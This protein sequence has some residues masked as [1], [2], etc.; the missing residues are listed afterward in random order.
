MDCIKLTNS[1]IVSKSFC[2]RTVQCSLYHCWCTSG[3]VV[4][5]LWWS[6]GH[7]DRLVIF[8]DLYYQYQCSDLFYLGRA[9]AWVHSWC[10]LLL[11]MRMSC[12]S[13]EVHPNDHAGNRSPN[14]S[15]HKPLHT[16]FIV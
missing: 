9:C 13:V 16:I 10:L 1:W 14:F 11:S 15:S 4:P 3:L 8:M 6:W 12:C 5:C 2:L 7:F